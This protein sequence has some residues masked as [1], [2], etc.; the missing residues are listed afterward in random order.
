MSFESRE[1]GRGR[2]WK[3]G[4]GGNVARG[5]DEEVERSLVVGR[6]A[7]D[8]LK[9]RKESSKKRLSSS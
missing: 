6:E 2:E 5:C 8:L 7:E 3:A 1:E 9:T 4:G